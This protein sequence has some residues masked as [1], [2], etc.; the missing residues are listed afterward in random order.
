LRSVLFSKYPS[1]DNTLFMNQ[2]LKDK[3]NLDDKLNIL[4]V[5]LEKIKNGPYPNMQS[6]SELEEKIIRYSQII[7]VGLNQ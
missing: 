7:I 5:K 4:S 1:P 2:L 3:S 6:I